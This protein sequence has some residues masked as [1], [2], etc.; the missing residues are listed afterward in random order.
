MENV[1]MTAIAIVLTFAGVAAVMLLFILALAW[2]QRKH[3][4]D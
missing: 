4:I 1:F 2:M 3:W